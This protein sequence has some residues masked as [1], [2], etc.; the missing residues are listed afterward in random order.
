MDHLLDAEEVLEAKKVRLVSA[1]L[2]EMRAMLLVSRLVGQV[3]WLCAFFVQMS[4]LFAIG[5]AGSILESFL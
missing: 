1:Q 4:Q 3:A 5:T 2:E